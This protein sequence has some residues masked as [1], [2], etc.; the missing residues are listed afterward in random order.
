MY[1]NTVCL[2]AMSSTIDGTRREGTACTS[3]ASDVPSSFWFGVGYSVVSFVCSVLLYISSCSVFFFCCR[4]RRNWNGDF[5]FPLAI[6]SFI[7]STSSV[8]VVN[9]SVAY[10]FEFLH[11][12]LFDSCCSILL[13]MISYYGL[14]VVSLSLKK[15]V[16]P[17]CIAL[18]L[19]D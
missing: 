2:L 12:F 18:V 6:F 11:G 4:V 9:N 10:P 17:S 14:L 5:I 8:S 3:G 1:I 16:S 19:L 7:L 15:K 13:F